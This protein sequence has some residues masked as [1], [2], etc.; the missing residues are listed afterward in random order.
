MRKFDLRKIAGFALAILLASVSSTAYSQTLLAQWRFETTD[1]PATPS[2]TPVLSTGSV[3]ADT[4]AN[5]STSSFTAFHSSASTVWST[6]VGN[7]SGNSLSSN[8]WAPG[9]Y[10][11]FQV[12]TLGYGGIGIAWGQTGS[13][14]GPQ[15]WKVQYSIDGTN[16]VDVPV[17]YP[18]ATYTVTNETWSATTANPLS[19]KTT[20]VTTL[21]VLFNQPMVYF[22]LV[23]APG[24]TAINGGAIGTGGTARIDDFSIGAMVVFPVKLTSFTATPG[25][26]GIT[27][28]WNTAVEEN[29]HSF[30]IERS[31]DGK[32]FSK[33]AEVEA[34]NHSS[35]S[36]YTYQDA[37]AKTGTLYYRLK[38]TDKDGSF[39]YS[40]VAMV[41][42]Q[43]KGGIKVYPNPV[44]DKLTINYEKAEKGASVEI[45]SLNG[46]R[47]VS[48]PLAIGT[49][50]AELNLSH[51]PKGTYIVVI[52]NGNQTYKQKLVKL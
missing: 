23:V 24:S 20:D 32:D 21:P 10:Y 22:R 37:T 46:T 16:F 44:A 33:I 52:V 42:L 6:P 7:G 50:E 15:T 47:L 45:M 31:T 39:T 30:V 5:V 18:G 34:S 4:G 27:L 43:F 38:M 19:V 11:Q 51:L 1:F 35:G 48:Q 3:L 40:N 13:N 9:D 8:N 26:Q 2:Q 12:S 17:V 41:N 25:E 36:S 28:N 14:T 29:A 49:A